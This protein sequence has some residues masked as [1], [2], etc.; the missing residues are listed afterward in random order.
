MLAWNDNASRA[1][2]ALWTIPAD[3]PRCEWLRAI[4]AAHAADIP[5]HEVAEWSAQA[6]SFNPRDFRDVWRSIKPG[7]GIGPG[8]LFTMAKQYGRAASRSQHQTRPATPTRPQLDPNAIWQRCEPATP[9]HPYVVAKG[10]EGA[11][12]DDLRVV[13]EGDGLRIAGESMAGA[14]VVP[15]RRADGSLA[16]LQLIAP[17]D[18]AARL[19]AKEKPGKLNL[20]GCPVDGWHVVGD[21][22]AKGGHV[23]VVE[24]IGQAWACWRATGS[25]AVVAFGAGRMRAA[26]LA[27]KARRT[28][29]TVVL[30]PDRG[31]ES[32]AERIAAEVGGSVVFMP[33]DTPQ[34]FDAADLAT[35]DGANALAELLGNPRRPGVARAWEPWPEDGTAQAEAAE[36]VPP[37]ALVPIADLATAEPPAPEFWIADYLPAGVVTLLGAHGGTGKSFLA[38]QAAVSIAAGRDFLGV[39]TRRGRVAFFSGEDPGELLRHRLAWLCRALAVEPAELAGRLHL[40]DATAGDPVLYQETRGHGHHGGGTTPTYEA[41]REFAARHEIDVLIVDNASDAFDANENDR[42]RVRAFMRSLGRIARERRGAVLLLAHVDKGTSRKERSDSEGYSGTTAW[43]NSARSRLYLSRSTDGALLLEHQKANL[44]PLRQP[45]ALRW[46][47]GNAIEPDAPLSGVV[48]AIEDSN[49][50]RALLRLIHEF[51]E[52]GEFVSTATTSRTHAGKLLRREPGFPARLRDP[53]LFDLL[54]RAERRGLLARAEYRGADRKSRERWQL[55]ASGLAAA[56]IESAATAA[57]SRD[58]TDRTPTAEAAEP[59]GDCGDFA[60]GMG[61]RARTPSALESDA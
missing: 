43:H 59:R 29:A 14:L 16:T 23:Y 37:F 17:H 56:G 57:T 58:L 61:E 39:E 7:G 45:I 3:L 26:A 49:S 40:I 4:M 52:R 41:L 44:G 10:A 12:L 32:A 35:R 19:K 60:G 21:L 25:A 51:T 33:D 13:P 31:Q 20:P 36:H 24:G 30:V 55:T 1:R 8:T 9:G 34:N 46:P 53:E 27:M 22:P 47:T 2:E 38:L 18:T 15:V 42:A 48:Q 11:P 5:E 28:G 50:T 6:D 54:R